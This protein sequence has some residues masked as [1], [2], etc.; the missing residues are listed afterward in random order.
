MNVVQIFGLKEKLDIWNYM[1]KILS[2]IVGWARLLTSGNCSIFFF[3]HCCYLGLIAESM[4]L[5]KQARTGFKQCFKHLESSPFY[6]MPQLAVTG[7][8]NKD[9]MP[10]ERIITVLTSNVQEVSVIEA[11]SSQ[12]W[13]IIR[14]G[15]S[16]M[17]VS[18]SSFFL[19]CVRSYLSLS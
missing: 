19:C 18:D 5:S 9:L 2:L 15:L 17:I 8:E 4:K 13:R 6:R 3:F 10:R 11:R 16:G 12:L 14:M 1:Y 7:L